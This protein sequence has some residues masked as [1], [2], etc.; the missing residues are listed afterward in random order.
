MKAAV[1]K[2]PEQ[3]EVVEKPRPR[4]G[5]GE[6]LIRVA[7]CGICGSDLHAYH[8]GFLPTDLTI[9]HEF[10]GVIAETGPGCAQWSP[11]ERVTGN[12]ILSCG[13]CSA[14]RAGAPN[15]CRDMTRLGITGDGA[16]AEYM[17]LPAR[18]LCRLP[19]HLPL[20]YGAFTEP[21]AVG[22]H[23]VHKVSLDGVQSALVIGAGTIGLVVIGL[24]KQRG[25]KQIIAVE[26]DPERCSI[27]IKM[28]ATAVLNP[29]EESVE[30]VLEKQ[31]GQR[32]APLVFECAGHP[33]T[34]RE[35]CNVAAPGATVVVL[36]ICYQP[37]E[38]NFLSLVTGEVEI[39]TA[40]GKTRE[41]IT[42]AVHLMGR[43]LFDPAP[44]LSGIIPLSA[45]QEEFAA[46][47]GGKI[48][49]LV[50]TGDRP[51]ETGEKP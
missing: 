22:L 29:L 3:L 27:A 28:G 23:A 31:T 13:Q 34:I 9:G 37:V 8:T 21:L 6:A 43:G 44:M 20:E 48:K 1:I 15:R 35:A 47:T 45:L 36:S 42:E 38:L 2:G 33:A 50:D 32:A 46:N 51:V 5:S 11:G 49:T 16:M 40:F 24:L 17:L 30:S 14:C 10:S 4:P 25:L 7:Y 26:P 39:K 12:N 19:D 18:E 41:E